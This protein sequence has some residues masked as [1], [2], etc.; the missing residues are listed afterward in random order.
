MAR[1][2]FVLLCAVALL[3]GCSGEGASNTNTFEVI[4]VPSVGTLA[5]R[6]NQ[7]FPDGVDQLMCDN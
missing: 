2:L 3:S 6:Y 4:T 1:H 5:L 7:P